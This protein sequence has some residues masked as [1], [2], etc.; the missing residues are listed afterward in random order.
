MQA[1]MSNEI[2]RRR[3]P[4]VKT[5]NQM[6]LRKVPDDIKEY[7]K[8]YKEQLN[9]GNTGHSYSMQEI[10]YMAIREFMKKNPLDKPRKQ[11]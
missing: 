8:R 5:L 11:K 9:S 1:V 7:L 2:F 10:I 4:K 3:L 6:I